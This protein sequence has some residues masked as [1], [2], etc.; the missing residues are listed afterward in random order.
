[1]ARH[2]NELDELIEYQEKQYVPHANHMQNGKLSYP[3]RQLAKQPGKAAVLYLLLLPG[4]LVVVMGAL[5]R[6]LEDQGDTGSLI[7]GITAVAVAILYIIVIVY[8]F[9]KAKRIQRDVQAQK[10]QQKRRKK[11]R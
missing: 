8:N 6:F 2:N 10:K 3:M 7:S 9:R 1:M 5:S 11:R 4:I